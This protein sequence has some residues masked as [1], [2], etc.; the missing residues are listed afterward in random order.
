MSAF[1]AKTGSGEQQQRELREG[2]PNLDTVNR[3]KGCARCSSAFVNAAGEGSPSRLLKSAPQ[4]DT[5]GSDAFL[6]ADA[7]VACVHPAQATS[8]TEAM[9]DRSC[10][11]SLG[12]AS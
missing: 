1:E 7:S 11:D 10:R 4:S 9:L 5:A 6:R 2:A 8:E 3:W 12:R